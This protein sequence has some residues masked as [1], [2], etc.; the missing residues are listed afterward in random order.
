MFP[1][2]S[3]VCLVM[4]KIFFLVLFT[5]RH[6]WFAKHGPLFVF[7]DGLFCFVSHQQHTVSFLSSNALSSVFFSWAV[8]CSHAP[9]INEWR[10]H[11]AREVPL[12]QG[13]SFFFTC[14]VEKMAI[15][16]PCVCVRVEGSSFSFGPSIPGFGK[17]HNSV[18]ACI[19]AIFSSNSSCV[20]GGWPRITY[21][22]E[23]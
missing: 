22:A 8:S 7:Y 12:F 4:L 6:R 11:G 19:L 15:W 13:L 10:L 5:L 18:C 16:G 2:E 14:T 17:G 20:F 23:Y 3:N 9:V 1:A 21:E